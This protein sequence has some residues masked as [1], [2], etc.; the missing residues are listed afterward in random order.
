MWNSGKALEENLAA[1]RV[2]G[3][4]EKKMPESALQRVCLC[5]LFLLFPLAVGWAP[6][7]VE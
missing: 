1:A 5:L 2:K 7:E 3:C 6:K 4:R